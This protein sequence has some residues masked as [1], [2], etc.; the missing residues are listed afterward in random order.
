MNTGYAIVMA[1]F[2]V[3]AAIMLAGAD[4]A[5]ATNLFFGG[6]SVFPGIAFLFFGV[7][8]GLLGLVK[9]RKNKQS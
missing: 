3:G 9:A 4:I 7:I 2:F 5:H 1:G 6:W 8:G